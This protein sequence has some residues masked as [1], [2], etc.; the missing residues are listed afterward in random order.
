MAQATGSSDG[1]PRFCLLEDIL[2]L[3]MLSAVVIA[4]GFIGREEKCVDCVVKYL[5]NSLLYCVTQSNAHRIKWYWVA[6][7]D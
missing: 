2:E 7:L 1:T 6:S 5:A 4:S 3:K